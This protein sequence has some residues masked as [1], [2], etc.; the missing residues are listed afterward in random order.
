MQPAR[1]SKTVSWA[2]G[3]PL[4]QV[5]NFTSEDCSSKIGNK[6]KADFQAK[7][8]S[9]CPS[10]LEYD[11]LPPGFEGYHFQNPSKSAFSYIKWEC[12]PSFVLNSC[13]SVAA[14][15]QSVDKYDEMLREMRVSEPYYPCISAI[16]PSPFV[17]F[18]LENECYDDSL[19]PVIPL[20]P[21]EEYE[22]VTGMK[23]DVSVTKHGN[24]LSK[25]QTQNTQ[26][27]IPPATSSEANFVAAS[28]AAVLSAILK[29]IEEG[30]LMIDV[31]FLLKIANDPKMIR[32]I[33]EEYSTTTTGM[34]T[35]SRTVSARQSTP[36]NSLLALTP[37]MCEI[38]SISL[39]AYAHDNHLTATPLVPLSGP[40]SA[41]TTTMTHSV[42]ITTAPHVHMPVK[43]VNYYR[44]LVR[45]YGGISEP[46]MQ[47]H[48]FQAYKRA[49]VLNPEEVKRKIQ[50]SCKYY[51]SS[52]GCG[53]GSK[54][55]YLHDKV[56]RM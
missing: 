15:E 7:T 45:K 46:D 4:C 20:I 50:K 10:T 33:M 55:R 43:D 17:S 27:Y 49:R 54:C 21:I 42:A 24:S 41:H 30:I 51:K 18:N 1:K 6:S 5:K 38:P 11:D 53:H 52:R 23:P 44:N 40:V 2:P 22:S 14:G 13:W 37:E 29:S 12:P 19:T 26:Q 56:W 48:N 9:T 31:D 16:P 8:V 39:L 36:S 32:K 25:L 28:I 34:S 3:F 35:P 47:N